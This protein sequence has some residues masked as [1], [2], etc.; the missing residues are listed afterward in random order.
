MNN[1]AI[2]NERPRNLKRTYLVSYRV[3]PGRAIRD[4][5]ET[6]AKSMNF[7]PE[8]AITALLAKCIEHNITL[9]PQ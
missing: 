7:T 8:D 3:K 9:L 2:T 4:Y 1:D 6:Q 5:V